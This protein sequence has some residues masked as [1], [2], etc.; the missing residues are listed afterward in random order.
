MVATRPPFYADEEEPSFRRYNSRGQG[1][2]LSHDRELPSA[3]YNNRDL[4]SNHDSR[5]GNHAPESDNNSRPRSRI[6]VA[7]SAASLSKLCL[8]SDNDSVDDVES[9]RSDAVVT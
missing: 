1:Y 8:K 6:P 4:L 9:E 2:S 3:P 7:V 5:G